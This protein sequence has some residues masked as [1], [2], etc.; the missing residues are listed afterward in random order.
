M[1]LRRQ[2][3][4]IRFSLVRHIPCIINSNSYDFGLERKCIKYLYFGFITNRVGRVLT[5]VTSKKKVTRICV[6]Y[7]TKVREITK[8]MCLCQLTFIVKGIHLTF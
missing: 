5:F 6:V 3:A 4:I 1:R 2:L 7:L 8:I